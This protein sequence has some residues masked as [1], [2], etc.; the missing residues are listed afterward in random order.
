MHIFP[1]DPP[2]LVWEVSA[3]GALAGRGAAGGADVGVIND[4]WVSLSLAIATT[5]VQMIVDP[6]R[7]TFVLLTYSNSPCI[8]RSRQGI[9]QCKVASSLAAIDLH[10][11]STRR[12]KLAELSFT[13][14]LSAK[15]FALN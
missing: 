4:A 14:G 8:S 12:T 13:S 5:S 7:V 10:S 9:K 11:Y 6:W 15:Y 3:A 2:G 1:F